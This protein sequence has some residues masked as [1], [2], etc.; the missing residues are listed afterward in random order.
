VLLSSV[1]EIVES[2]EKLHNGIEEWNNGR[3]A[4]L[5]TSGIS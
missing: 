2:V 5:N 4:F 1:G 3:I